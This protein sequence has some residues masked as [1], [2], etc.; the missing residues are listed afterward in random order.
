LLLEDYIPVAVFVIVGLLF[1]LVLFVVSSLL[2]PSKFEPEKY[3]TYECSIPPT[4]DARIQHNV[5][6]YLFAIIFIVFDVE[7]VFLYP[8]A[9]VFTNPALGVLPFIEMMLFIGVLVV[10]LAYAWKKGALEWL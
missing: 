10:G 1:P 7:L 9:V 2:R 8:W 4:G 3:T 5:Q 6:Y